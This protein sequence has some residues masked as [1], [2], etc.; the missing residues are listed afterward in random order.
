MG[1]VGQHWDQPASCRKHGGGRREGGGREGWRAYHGAQGAWLVVECTDSWAGLHLAPSFSPAR[2]TAG[3]A[4][5]ELG[6]REVGPERSSSKNNSSHNCT[7][8]TTTTTSTSST[9]AGRAVRGEVTAAGRRQ[10]SSFPVSWTGGTRGRQGRQTNRL[11]WAGGQLGELARHGGWRAKPCM[12]WWEV[13]GHLSYHTDGRLATVTLAP[14]EQWTLSEVVETA[15][16]GLSDVNMTATVPVISR[17]DPPTS[18]N[19]SRGSGQEVEEHFCHH[20]GSG[21]RRLI[22]AHPDQH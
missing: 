9:A 13:G 14:V 19:I 7:T 16:I 8:T 5:A 22:E 12:L 4:R 21:A 3:R 6:V 10:H 20:A 2:P 17:P 1:T 15:Q 18:W 11:A